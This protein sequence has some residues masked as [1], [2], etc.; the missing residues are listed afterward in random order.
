M[1]QGFPRVGFL[2]CRCPGT[3]VLWTCAKRFLLLCRLLLFCRPCFAVFVALPSSVVHHPRHL[4]EP[5]EERQT[6]SLKK[7][8]PST[9]VLAMRANAHRQHRRCHTLCFSLRYP[10]FVLRFVSQIGCVCG[11]F[12]VWGL[13]PS[14]RPAPPFRI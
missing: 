12:M 4:H 7:I 14:E 8:N 11:C 6:S 9:S 10:G 3:A 13:K 1:S 2:A 5:C